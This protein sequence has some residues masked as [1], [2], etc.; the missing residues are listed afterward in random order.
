MA[1]GRHWSGGKARG[2]DQASSNQA[3]DTA[4]AH[5]PLPHMAHPLGNRQCQVGE[6]PRQCFVPQSLAGRADADVSRGSGAVTNGP[7]TA[8]R[9][10]C[11]VT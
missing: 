5:V 2:D 4:T 11:R 6:R 7:T 9:L 3:G 1:L 8:R 10:P